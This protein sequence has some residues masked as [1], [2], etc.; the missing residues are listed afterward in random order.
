MFGKTMLSVGALLLARATAE[1]APGFPID[2]SQ[3][4]T[5]TYG[6]NTVSPGG[7]L[8]PRPGTYH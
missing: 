3:N 8:I 7:E 1:T 4:L 2:V 5:I 6:N